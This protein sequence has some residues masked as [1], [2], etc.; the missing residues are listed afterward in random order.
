M[1]PELPSVVA[2][3]SRL[4]MKFARTQTPRQSF[5]IGVELGEFAVVE[6]AYRSEQRQWVS[7]PPALRVGHEVDCST[8]LQF[9]HAPGPHR[10][11]WWI[12]IRQCRRNG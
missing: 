4:V 7:A 10:R 1:A 9:L 11:I 8:P 2:P 5:G 12:G 3:P 6:L